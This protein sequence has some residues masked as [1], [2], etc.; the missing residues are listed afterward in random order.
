M[1]H[2]S[3]IFYLASWLVFIVS[4]GMLV[5]AFIEWL[6]QGDDGWIFMGCSIG[7][8]FLCAL[9]ICV[10]RPR[11]KQPLSIQD[12]FL[13]TVI[14]W[15]ASIL[16]A[17][18]PLTFGSL[19]LP[20]VDAFFQASSMLTTTGSNVILELSKCSKGIL[21]WCS[22]LQWLGGKG[23]ILMALILMPVLR[24]GGMQLFN[25][26]SSEKSEKF[27][28][29]VTQI[30]SFIFL[31][32][33][34]LTILCAGLLWGLG[35]SFF[36]AVCHGMTT[37]STG[38]FSTWDTSIQK[39]DSLWVQ[40]VMTIFMYLGGCTFFIIAETMH[41]KLGTFFKDD[42]I[43][44]FTGIILVTACIVGVWRYMTG[45]DDIL[46]VFIESLFNITSVITTTG[47]VSA[48]YTL[49]GTLAMMVFFFLPFIGGCTGSTAGGIKVF[50]FQILVKAALTQ[51]KKLRRPH[52]MFTPTYGG[53][54]ISQS[55]FN[56]IV[57]FFVFYV[58]TFVI[59]CLI[60]STAGLDFITTISSVSAS[61]TNLGPGLGD[62]I[63]PS[64]NYDG[65]D[66]Y[67]K[68]VLSFSMIMGRIELVGILV[69]FM[70]SFW[71]K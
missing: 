8:T 68:W 21:L 66:N 56:S 33:T 40:F 28:P 18:L 48:D 15:L 58:L 38:G 36:D 27:L 70:P 69:L 52:G 54:V 7:M 29:R 59:L 14:A 4:G 39:V 50:R 6:Y 61:L 22:I 16:I 1:I 12:A 26:E 57:S 17:S 13:L 49:W 51:L 31:I 43:R 63:G 46:Y 37:L 30:A 65:L 5:P 2:F 64:G 9:I 19:E 3:Y 62:I 20:F 67:I 41:G 71:K 60:V 32:Y 24:I 23:I 45:D 47:F 10:T 55:V 42:Q 53:R 34:L 44:A 11:E 35:F 25:T